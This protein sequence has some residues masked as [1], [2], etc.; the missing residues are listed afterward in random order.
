M[1][2]SIRT[3]FDTAEKLRKSLDNAS[4]SNSTT[5]QAN[6][7]ATIYAYEE[8]RQLADRISLFSHNETLDDISSTD[9]RYLLIDYQLAELTIK[10]TASDRRDVLLR[11]REQFERFLNLLD[12]YGIL[13]KGDK[14]LYEQY[15]DAPNSFSTISTTDAALRRESKIARFREEKGLKRK[16]E[17]LDQDPAALRNDDALLREI[18]LTNI[19][20][21]THYTFQALESISQELQIL[22][23]VPS[24]PTPETLA[25]DHRTRNEH[26]TNAF[27][28]RL[29][30]PFSQLAN[31]VGG[32]P[33]LSRDGKPLKPFTLLDS[34]QHLQQGVF[35][36]G[37]NLPTMTIDEYLKE[38]KRRGGIIEGGG[39]QSGLRP[40]PD[41]DN[42]DRADEE[43]M[44]ARDWDEFTES[45]PKG[46]GNTLNRG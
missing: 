30:T 10:S 22:A 33:I 6:C 5:S 24:T 14:K 3:L 12:T 46:S 17:H 27:S 1:S 11:A 20:L 31:S 25:P 26:G 13:S 37:H 35:K 8:C 39:E 34:R 41:E 32:G 44:K 29:D 4:Q 7:T 16:I 23:L 18:H 19:S 43:T 28:D 40:E 15:L 42:F 36:S 2:Q 38:E 9:L 21:C 45:N